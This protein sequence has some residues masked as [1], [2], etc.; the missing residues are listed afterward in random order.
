MTGDVDLL[1][2]ALT[3][4]GWLELVSIHFVTLAEAGLPS[5]IDDRTIWHFCQTERMLL[6]TANRSMKGRD[7]L[8]AV[9]REENQLDSLP[10]ITVGNRDSLSDPAYRKRCIERLVDIVVDI[11]SQLGRRRIFIP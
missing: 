10:V 2:G 5:N 8:E 6:L 9:L 1:V 3:A 4:T 11:E 7:S